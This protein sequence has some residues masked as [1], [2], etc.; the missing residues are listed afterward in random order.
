MKRRAHVGF[1]EVKQ[2]PFPF[3]R[4]PESD[5]VRTQLRRSACTTRVRP[6]EKQE[7]G[8]LLEAE[9][10]VNTGRSQK[11]RDGRVDVRRTRHFGAAAEQ[12]G[13]EEGR[14]ELN[15][16]AAKAGILVPVALAA[17]RRPRTAGRAGDGHGDDVG[18]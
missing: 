15:L 13:A 18:A 1:P 5:Q 8:V 11:R 2:C 7:L 9:Q 4:Q 6:K 10:L 12:V 16:V 17:Y 14:D 3:L